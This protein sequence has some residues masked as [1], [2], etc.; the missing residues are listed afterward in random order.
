MYSLKNSSDHGEAL[1]YSIKLPSIK[2][3]PLKFILFLFKHEK[4]NS[5]LKSGVPIFQVLG[6]SAN[7]LFNLRCK[8]T[9]VMM[10]NFCY[11]PSSL[12]CYSR[13]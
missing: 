3:S 13:N 8:T 10:E 1:V 9:I 2:V 7:F 5:N 12:K 6:N 4:V 11:R